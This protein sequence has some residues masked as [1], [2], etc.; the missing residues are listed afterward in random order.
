M[1]E[2]KLGVKNNEKRKKK[3]NKI[4]DV[5]GFGDG[6]MDFLDGIENKI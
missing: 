5:E 1:L 6:F 3:L 2:K 4:I